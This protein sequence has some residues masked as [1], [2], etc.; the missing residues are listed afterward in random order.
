MIICSSP[1]IQLKGQVCLPFTGEV[2][3]L[4]SR[5]IISALKTTNIALER[6]PDFF[7]KWSYLASSYQLD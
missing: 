4:Y 2:A 1:L 6:D 3:N 5:I 7:Q